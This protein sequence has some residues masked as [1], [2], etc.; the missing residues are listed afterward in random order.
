MACASSELLR[1]CL[2]KKDTIPMKLCFS[3]AF[4]S[5]AS[6]PKRNISGGERD[7]GGVSTWAGGWYNGRINAT[8]EGTYDN[9]PAP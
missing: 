3:T 9:G 2:D 6:V 8:V 5:L 4:F 1:A 7:F